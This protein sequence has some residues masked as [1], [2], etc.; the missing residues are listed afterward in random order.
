MKQAGNIRRPYFAQAVAVISLCRFLARHYESLTKEQRTA[1]TVEP[2]E[3]YVVDLL[4]ILRPPCRVDNSTRACRESLAALQVAAASVP[5]FKNFD[6]NAP[7]DTRVGEALV[8]ARKEIQGCFDHFGVGTS[9]STIN[10][11][12]LSLTALR[13]TADLALG[14]LRE[15]LQAGRRKG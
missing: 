12:L 11:M 10:S 5:T 7:E 1:T 9:L 6:M 8:A 3:E 4:E 13:Y 2:L 14:S 15:D